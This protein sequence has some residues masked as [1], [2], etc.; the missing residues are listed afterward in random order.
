MQISTLLLHLIVG[1]CLSTH[2]YSIFLTFVVLFYRHLH[3]KTVHHTIKS[4]IYE[5]WKWPVQSVH[6][7][8]IY[9]MLPFSPQICIYCLRSR[10]Y[11]IGVTFEAYIIYHLTFKA[12]QLNLYSWALTFKRAMWLLLP[13]NISMVNKPNPWTLC[14]CGWKKT[15]AL[16]SSIYSFL[17]FTIGKYY[18]GFYQPILRLPDL[19]C[20]AEML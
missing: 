10:F 12:L 17:Y 20:L 3:R 11:S 4:L 18:G 16:Q 13:L 5:S 9:S 7:S 14:Q 8:Y 19:C 15:S 2:I 1:C 6:V